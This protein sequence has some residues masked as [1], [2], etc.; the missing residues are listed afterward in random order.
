MSQHPLN[1]R[2][3]LVDDDDTHLELSEMAL[4]RIDASFIFNTAGSAEKAL[5]LIHGQTFD[6]IVSNYTMYRMN[7]VEFCERLRGEGCDTPFIL[8]TC[9][10]D[11]KMVERAFKAGVD[12]YLEKGPSLDVYIVLVQRIMNLVS[13]HRV[14]ERS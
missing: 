9:R 3:L 1:L 8:F 4:R 12:S 6:C 14:E 10:D 7:G 5:E 13:T 11:E 2:V